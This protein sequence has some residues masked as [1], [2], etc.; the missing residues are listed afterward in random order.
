MKHS[1]I[2]SKKWRLLLCLGALVAAGAIARF[3][4]PLPFFNSSANAPA[5][6]IPE[7][8]PTYLPAPVTHPEA[9]T[10]T[11]KEASSPPPTTAPQ[12]AVDL[13][14]PKAFLLQEQQ[15]ETHADI[16][17]MLVY[18]LEHGAG[19]TEDEIAQILDN[20]RDDYSNILYLYEWYVQSAL[21]TFD[22][23]VLETSELGENTYLRGS[24]FLLLVDVAHSSN[25]AIPTGQQRWV[26][27]TADPPYGIACFV[28]EYLLT[29]EEYQLRRE[30]HS[31]TTEIALVDELRSLFISTSFADITALP[32]DGLSFYVLYRAKRE[33]MYPDTLSLTQ[34]QMDAA[35]KRFV[36][37]DHLDPPQSFASFNIRDIYDPETGLY[38]A[39]GFGPPYCY[40]FFWRVREDENGVYLDYRLPSE[41]LR[42]TI[43]DG[44]IRS[45]VDISA[46]IAGEASGEII[47]QHTSFY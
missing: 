13:S 12:P 47:G 25:P 7:P 16:C 26:L 11:P 27:Q 8:E 43:K 4:L 6:T 45:A 20:P 35:A 34:E 9:V 38:T 1:F 22:V 5:P 46:E 10:T 23:T 39:Y 24:E 19:L 37:L 29:W 21:H 31:Y 18:L 41:P 42:Y 15:L 3:F 14:D 40:D 17:T 32:N 2:F 30:A 28:P 44:I 33:K 36:G